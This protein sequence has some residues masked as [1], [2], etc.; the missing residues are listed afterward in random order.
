MA[1]DDERRED[2]EP[3]TAT[4][5][6]DLESS[7]AGTADQIVGTPGWAAASGAAQLEHERAEREAAAAEDAQG[8]GE[9]GPGGTPGYGSSGQEGQ[10]AG[11][12]DRPPGGSG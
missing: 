7:E 2:E 12:A 4:A 5:G 3:L 10:G 9:S 11:S 6:T 1:G 8:A